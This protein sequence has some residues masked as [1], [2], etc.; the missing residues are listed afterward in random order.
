MEVIEI[1]NIFSW[2][3]GFSKIWKCVSRFISEIP[4]LSVTT[5]RLTTRFNL[6]PYVINISFSNILSR[7]H[8]KWIIR[9]S[10]ATG[11]D[12]NMKWTCE[13]LMFHTWRR[14]KLFSTYLFCWRCIL[15]W[16]LCIACQ[17]NVLRTLSIPELT[18]YK[19]RDCGSSDRTASS[20]YHLRTPLARN[21]RRTCKWQKTARYQTH[22]SNVVCHLDT[23]HYEIL[24]Q[25]IFF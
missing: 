6:S 4:Q 23:C 14:I 3:I 19:L 24:L 17:P 25:Q 2:T 15:L 1:L 18:F 12:D 13:I 10:S 16:S 7:T 22:R 20:P 9:Y 21:H 5:Q 11:F 8:L